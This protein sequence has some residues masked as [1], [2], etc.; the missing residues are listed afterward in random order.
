MFEK[1]CFSG[2]FSPKNTLCC[3][4]FWLEEG[5]IHAPLLISSLHQTYAVESV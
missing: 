4:Y 5:R 3:F 1:N 2:V